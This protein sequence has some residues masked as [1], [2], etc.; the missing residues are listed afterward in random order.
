MEA[1][2]DPLALP[3]LLPDR[4]VAVGDHWRVGGDAARG[5]S[6]YDAL[7]ANALDATVESL[8]ATAAVFRLKGEIRGAALGGEGT[9]A[10]DGTLPSTAWRA[11][12]PGS[13]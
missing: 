4:P 8:D 5:L 7:A 9:I 1:V 11:R 12:S 10:C 6:G 13:S 2:G 3:G